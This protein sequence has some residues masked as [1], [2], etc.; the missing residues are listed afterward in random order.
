MAQSS[1]GLAPPAN[2]PDQERGLIWFKI[3]P[4]GAGLSPALGLFTLFIPKP[5]QEFRA[6]AKERRDLYLGQPIDQL[7]IYFEEG[8]K[9]VFGRRADVLQQSLLQ[10]HKAVLYQ[11]PENT[12]ELGRLRI[13]DDQIVPADL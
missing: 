1:A 2:E 12:I 4:G 13:Q 7:W 5:A 11:Y 8:I 3:I 9:A 6:D 10:A